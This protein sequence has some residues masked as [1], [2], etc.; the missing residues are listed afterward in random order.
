MPWPKIWRRLTEPHRRA[1]AGWGETGLLDANKSND[2]GYHY[3]GNIHLAGAIKMSIM[4]HKSTFRQI[5]FF[6]VLLLVL[7]MTS[8]T[9]IVMNLLLDGPEKLAGTQKDRNY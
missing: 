7:S 4:A 2:E 6:L 9:L 8:C 5:I 3:R 1:P